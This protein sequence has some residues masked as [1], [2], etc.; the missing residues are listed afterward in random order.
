M[1]TGNNPGN[2]EASIEVM[3]VEL[4]RKKGKVCTCFVQLWAWQWKIY[5]SRK[6][7]VTESFENSLKWLIESL[8]HCLVRRNQ[9]KFSKDIKVL[10]SEECITQ[11]KTLLY[12][13]KTRKVKDTRIKFVPRRKIWK[14]H[15][16]NIKSDFRSYSPQEV[17][18]K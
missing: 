17:Q 7:Q 8:M 18:G 9:R 6:G 13:F 1:I 3:V 15:K 4:E 10:S 14:L 11:H 12:D 16:D 2:Y 5:S